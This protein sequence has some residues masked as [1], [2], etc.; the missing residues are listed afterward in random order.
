M[1]AK[2]WPMAFPPVPSF[3]PPNHLQRRCTGFYT[4]WP[5]LK[6]TIKKNRASPHPNNQLPTR[7]L[8]LIPFR[9]ISQGYSSLLSHR[10]KG[11]RLT[12]YPSRALKRM[13]SWFF[14]FGKIYT[15]STSSYNRPCTQARKGIGTMSTAMKSA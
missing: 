6:D 3:P 13:V 2:C 8:S 11:E 5:Y 15:Q 4:H 7:S 1:K 10:G 12:L 14:F 9:F